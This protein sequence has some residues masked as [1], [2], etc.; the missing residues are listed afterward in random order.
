MPMIISDEF[1]TRLHTLRR[2]HQALQRAYPHLCW[3][4]RDIL[5]AA[6]TQDLRALMEALLHAKILLDHSEVRCTCETPMALA[7]SCTGH[8]Q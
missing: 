8:C 2:E 5:A 7:D 1:R 4:L 3:A 6:D